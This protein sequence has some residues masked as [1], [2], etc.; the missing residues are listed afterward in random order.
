MLFSLCLVPLSPVLF[1]F[2]HRVVTEHFFL[3]CLT[4]SH[5]GDW[6]TTHHSLLLIETVPILKREVGCWGQTGSRRSNFSSSPRGL[7]GTFKS[8]KRIRQ[9]AV[10]LISYFS[11]KNKSDRMNLNSF[12]S[13]TDCGILGAFITPLSPTW[14]LKGVTITGPTRQQ[15]FNKWVN[16]LKAF[17]MLF[18]I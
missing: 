1:L 2:E 12:P 15:C 13:C 5:Q 4:P 17:S 3:W 10:C 7:S 6:T 18:R 16:P 9:R 14:H 11:V 8:Q